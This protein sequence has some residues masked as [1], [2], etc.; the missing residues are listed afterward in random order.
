MQQLTQK[1]KTGQMRIIDASLP[2]LQ[3]GCVLVKNHYSLISA[4]TEGS[5]VK[6]ARKG[7][8][9]KAKDRPQQVKQV[10]NTLKTQGITQTYRAVMKK[11]DAYSPLGYSCAGKIIDLASDVNGFSVGDLV[12]CGGLTASHSEV[13]SVPAN[14]CVK[15]S[16]EADLKQAAYNT[17][18]A[19]ALQGV[20]QANLRL[21]ETCAV[22]GDGAVGTTEMI[23]A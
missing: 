8:I 13:V 19:I 21:G 11:L 23:L 22:I 1:L 14:L 15:L 7:Y 2:F 12:A 6:A 3:R 18:G 9:G 16:P 10:I 5:T 17:L 20:R 4:G